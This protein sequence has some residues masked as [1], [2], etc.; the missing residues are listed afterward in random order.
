VS[1]FKL[2]DESYLPKPKSPGSTT[3]SKDLVMLT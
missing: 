3:S 1:S 2:P